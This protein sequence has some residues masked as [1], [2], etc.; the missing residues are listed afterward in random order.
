M[1]PIV[2]T[3]TGKVSVVESLSGA[4]GPEWIIGNVR[5]DGTLQIRPAT[6]Y[7]PDAVKTAIGNLKRNDL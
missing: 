6:D 2:C 3:D 4:M 1:K 5:K 7:M